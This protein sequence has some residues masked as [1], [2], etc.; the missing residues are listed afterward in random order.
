MS[1]F[2]NRLKHLNYEGIHQE[3]DYVL[4]WM[5]ASQ[6]YEYNH[7]LQYAIQ[8]ANQKDKPLIVY[9]CL[10]ADFPE[11]NR[12][13]FY[14]MLEG[15]LELKK[16]FKQENIPFIIENI[17]PVTGVTRLSK[18]ALTVITDKGYLKIQK[19]W[20][21]EIAKN[22][23]CPLIE[24]ETDIVVP[25]EE[26]SK[27]EEY[28]AYTLRKKI[29]SKKIDYLLPFSIE[30]LNHT[31]HPLHGF[32]S[33]TL[34]SKKDI[35]RIINDLGLTNTLKEVSFFTGGYS[36]AKKK[37]NDF[38]NHHMTC[39]S[40]NSNDPTNPITSNLSPYL[41]FGQISPI[42]IALEIMEAQK[43]GEE[44]FI[45]QLIVRRELAINF[46][47]YNENYDGQL[48]D[49]LHDW[50]LRTMDEHKNDPRKYNY[51]LETLEK[52]KT[53]DSYWNAAQKQL[54][55]T[56]DMHNY[57]R[58]YWGKKVLEWTDHYQIAYNHL[59]YLNNKYAL[60]GRDANSFA[61]IAWC[62][63]KHDRAWQERDIFGKIRYMNANGLKRK[64]KIDKY[65]QRINNLKE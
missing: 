65:I 35:I 33:V 47:Y 51:S 36:E 41:H 39:Y 38:I 23:M 25:V 52:A 24:I 26:A 53:H 19:Y 37:L 20:R 63:G 44:D 42:E 21:K 59:I 13:H 1:L 9:F 16:K 40:E 2:K 46:V 18:K 12:R 48:E 62:F 3:G 30:S 45:E 58:M 22:I 27:K 49:I 34:D 6:R 50:T 60:D 61:G 54:K 15:L 8:I 57:M 29:N 17:D 10:T 7:A 31:D 28:A 4:Y 64:F 14:F 43:P 5:Q 56:G 55:I 32:K 11:A